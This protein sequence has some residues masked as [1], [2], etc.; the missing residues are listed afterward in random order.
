MSAHL[1]EEQR[2]LAATGAL[3]AP[4]TEHLASCAVCQRDVKDAKARQGLLRGLRPYT[5]SDMAFRRVEARLV[6]QVEEGLPTPWPRW[7]WLALPL[8]VAVALLVVTTPWERP[9]S[10]EIATTMAPSGL[11]VARALPQLRVTLA[12]VDAKVRAQHQPEWEP[13]RATDPVSSGAALSASRVV[14]GSPDG[15]LVLEG[16]GSF[17]LGGQ[18]MTV[19]GAG[20]LALVGS[21]ETVAGGRRFVGVDAVFRVQRTGAEVV[22]DVHRGSV[23]VSDDGTNRRRTIAGPSRHRWAD[24]T[25]LEQGVDEAAATW[26]VPLPQKGVLSVLDLGA[27]PDGTLLSVDDLSLG[28]TPL[29]LGLEGGRHRVS[30]TPPGKPT[31]ERW[32]DLVGGSVTRFALAPEERPA[33]SPEPDAEALARVMEDLRRQ[34]PRLRA[35]YEK[36]L[37]A[38]PAASGT[39]DLVLLVSAR[40]AVKRVEVRGDPISK[41][42]ATCLK[43]TA[44]SLVLSPLGSEQEL[45]VPLLLTPGKR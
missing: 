25:A 14:L 1:S 35:C 7:L 27:L 32:I 23:E 36:W 18:A 12:S 29:S 24:G 33:A 17:A 22:L 3:Q 43:T 39:V 37:K 19:L 26:V 41:E 30:V 11:P 31:Q 8:G 10:P 44:R 42:S 9:V 4:H 45:E 6:E 28:A 13:L 40:G 34:T 16:E 21:G 20:S 5:L 2:E 38:N 15:A